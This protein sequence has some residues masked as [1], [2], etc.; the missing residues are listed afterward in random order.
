MHTSLPFKDGLMKPSEW[1]SMLSNIEG[2]KEPSRIFQVNVTSNI[3]FKD[4]E[5]NPGSYFIRTSEES[6]ACLKKLSS[7]RV[8]KLHSSE[9]IYISDLMTKNVFQKILEKNEILEEV[10]KGNGAA[11]LTAFLAENFPS[12]EGL[13][14]IRDKIQSRYFENSLSFILRRFF[15]AIANFF[16]KYNL[17]RTTGIYWP[18]NSHTYVCQVIAK[19]QNLIDIVLEANQEQ[20]AKHLEVSLDQV[21]ESNLDVL[22][23]EYLAKAKELHPD[24]NKGDEKA[25]KKIQTLNLIWEDFQ[26]IADF[27]NS[28]RKEEQIEDKSGKEEE[29]VLPT[30]NGPSSWVGVD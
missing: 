21:K 14:E 29:Q 8:R 11:F 27:N 7:A 22:R 10:N 16:R 12:A 9:L 6:L 25:T 18:G 17:Y 19:R 1:F 4:Q 5:I 24:Q 28:V 13:E 23:K 15:S 20:L 26:R 3:S 2:E 30:T